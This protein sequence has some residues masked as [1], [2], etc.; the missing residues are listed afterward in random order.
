MFA[1]WGNAHLLIDR[2]TLEGCLKLSS[3]PATQHIISPSSPPIPLSPQSFTTHRFLDPLC[4]AAQSLPFFP[5]HPP[6]H[7]TPNVALTN[8][9]THTHKMT[10]MGCQPRQVN[11]VNADGNCTVFSGF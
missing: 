11:G 5:T 3:H 4:Q 1:Q 8:W 9:S 6:Q 2:G 10:I 7:L